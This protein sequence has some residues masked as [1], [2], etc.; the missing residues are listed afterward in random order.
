MA[1]NILMDYYKRKVNLHFLIIKDFFWLK[2]FKHLDMQ[3]NYLIMSIYLSLIKK[4][5]QNVKYKYLF[6][7][8]KYVIKS[9]YWSYNLNKTIK[10][11]K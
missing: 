6:K 5:F 4:I 10:N 2:G 1:F 9:K 8:Y 11:K 3:V 7:K